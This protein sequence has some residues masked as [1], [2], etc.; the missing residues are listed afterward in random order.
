MKIT[1]KELKRMVQE[2]IREAAKEGVVQKSYKQSF[3]RMISKVASGGNKNTPPFI[4]K[5]SKPGK[6]GPDSSGY[7]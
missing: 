1:I 4:K 2:I 3:T 6:S 7:A 5:A